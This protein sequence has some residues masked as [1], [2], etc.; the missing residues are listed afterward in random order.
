LSFYYLK[1]ELVV[2]CRENNLQTRGSKIEI[3][4]RIVHFLKTGER[5]VT[6]YNSKK[7]DINGVITID[8]LIEPNFVCSE[9]HRE[10][11]KEKIGKT[12]SFNVIFQK[13]LKANAGKTYEDSINAY[14]QISE[15]KKKNK[16]IIDQQFEYNIYIRDFFNDNTNKKLEQAIKCWKYK[17]SLQGPNKYEKEDLEV[18]KD[19]NL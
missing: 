13:W 7:A 3:T 11:Y 17:K 5:L 4:N 9:K 18:L 12:F 16:T 6:N 10:F 1:E 2:F 14:Y 8:M 19:Y 15:E